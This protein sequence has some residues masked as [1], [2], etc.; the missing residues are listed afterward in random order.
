M[1]DPPVSG[2][3]NSTNGGSRA[4]V[5]NPTPT[6]SDGSHGF[7]GDA[8]V[9]SDGTPG[10][11]PTGS[12]KVVDSHSMTDQSVDMSPWTPPAGP[13]SPVT[14][15]TSTGSDGS[16]GFAGGATV[17]SDG[18][19]GN[20]PT[21]SFKVVDSHSMT[22]Q[23]VDMS[24][25]TPP[26]GPQSPVTNPTSTGSDG[27]HGF[28]GGATDQS[29]GLFGNAPTGSFKV[30]DSHSM[31]DQ[32]VDMSPWTPPAGPQ[33]PVTNPTPTGS[34]GSHGFPGG[35]TD[36]SGGT[37]GNA[38]TGSFTVVDSHSTTDQSSGG[39]PW[40][41]PAG[42]QPPVTNPASTGGDGSQ[43]FAFNFTGGESNST[44]GKSGDMLGNA[45]TGSFTVVDSHSITDQSSGM[46]PWI[47]P[48]GP[49][50]D[51]H[52]ITD[53]FGGLQTDAATALG[54]LQAQLHVNG[55]HVV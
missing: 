31:T 35:A 54:I 14:N 26:A 19:P 49:N 11:A 30:V 40:T 12:F 3:S 28:A 46:L 51:F 34:D 55:F 18:T 4:P 53:Q 36:Q 38:P 39:S 20:A 41:L 32:S 7:A 22:D 42:P 25:W 29:N 43:G 1:F 15:P 10:N 37:L 50:I 47:P 33:P 27:S 23:S 44:P 45:P 52:S 13:Q 17:Q 9:Q 5:T 24:P 48:A 2:T 6:G 16:H 8:T 21:G